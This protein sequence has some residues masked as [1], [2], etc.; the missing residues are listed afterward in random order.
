MSPLEKLKKDFPVF[1]VFNKTMVAKHIRLANGEDVQIQ[2][3]SY[4]SVLSNE[5][6]NIPDMSAFKM[7]SPST[8][9]L[10]KYGI[11]KKSTKAS[12][13]P[14]APETPAPNN[15]QS[16]NSGSGKSGSK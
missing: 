16:G 2:P 7:V 10:V 1:K 3:A 6:T 11:L 4:G 14:V 5:L 12:A 13:S 8:A 15:H 9:D